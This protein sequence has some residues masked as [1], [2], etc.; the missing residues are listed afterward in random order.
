MSKALIVHQMPGRMRIRIPAMRGNADYFSD[1][2]GKLGN[3]AGMAAVKANPATASIVMQFSGNPQGVLEHLRELDL[4]PTI[5]HHETQAA[6]GSGIR[7]VRLV[8]GRDINPM[9]M[10]GLTLA[11]VGLVQTYRGKVAVPSITAF[12]YAVEAFRASREKR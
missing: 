3:I 1:L 8:T 10:A 5:K 12:W 6:S 7:P 2:A 9:F 11:L 4:D